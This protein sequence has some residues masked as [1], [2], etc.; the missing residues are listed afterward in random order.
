ME[1]WTFT[2]PSPEGNWKPDLAGFG[3]VLMIDDEPRRF[4]IL[5]GYRIIPE[6]ARLETDAIAGMEAIAA[7]GPWDALLLDHDLY[8]KRPEG[9]DDY[10]GK[11]VARHLIGMP[12]RPAFVLVHSTNWRQA[13]IMVEA[14][15]EA[16]I[17]A[18]RMSI[19]DIYHALGLR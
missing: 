2:P 8:T 16:G 13:E 19:D 10:N 15:S 1:P 9:G 18:H 14:L 12:W 7:D 6:S 5:R 17:K 3:R 11:D 4:D